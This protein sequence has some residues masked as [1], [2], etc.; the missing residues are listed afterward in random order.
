MKNGAV[1]VFARRPELGYVK[2]RLAPVLGEHLTLAVYQAFLADTLLAAHEADATVLLAHTPGPSFKEQELADITF[3]QRGN[4]FGERFDNALLDA[5]YQLPKKTPLVL[6][7]ADTP[8]LS[9]KLLRNGL[10][11]LDEFGAVVGPSVNGGFYLLGFSTRPV[12]VTEAFTCPSMTETA[13]VVRL[14]SQAGIKPKLLEFSFDVDLPDDLRRLDRFIELL[15]AVGSDWV[16]RRT[17]EIL[18][19]V[20]ISL[21]IQEPKTSPSSQ[22]RGLSNHRLDLAKSTRKEGFM[23][24]KSLLDHEE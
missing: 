16:P 17:Q 8:H 15:E 11:L 5:I 9:P 10:N 20:E 2:T 3:E 12:P 13:E 7:G 1:L 24:S 14:I 4:T 6:I 23:L 19:E 22:Y 21:P 18:R